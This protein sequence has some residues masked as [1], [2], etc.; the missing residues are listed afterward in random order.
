MRSAGI[1]VRHAH[2]AQG[3][4]SGLLSCIAQLVS[5]SSLT[6]S[7]PQTQDPEL[8]ELAKV[9]LGCLGVVAEVTLQVGREQVAA[10][11][12][13]QAGCAAAGGKHNLLCVHVQQ[14]RDL[15]CKGILLRPV[16]A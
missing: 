5:V 10:G 14:L 2:P 12:W 7:R 8:F 15:P 1:Q 13:R 4:L 11:R 9:G 16:P 6:P 3:A